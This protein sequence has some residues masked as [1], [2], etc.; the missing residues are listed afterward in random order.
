M[1]HMVANRQ[2]MLDGQPWSVLPLS[3]HMRRRG[4]DE[5]ALVT[6]TRTPFLLNRAYYLLSYAEFANFASFTPVVAPFSARVDPWLIEA[7]PFEPCS[8]KSSGCVEHFADRAFDASSL[9]NGKLDTL[10]ASSIL[11]ALLLV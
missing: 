10:S 2:G 8:A 6:W 11:F 3:A 9:V 5:G 4:L 1:I 7:A